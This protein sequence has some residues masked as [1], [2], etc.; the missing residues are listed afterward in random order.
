MYDE[1]SR[2]LREMSIVRASQCART[3][4]IPC[5]TYTKTKKLTLPKREK[6]FLFFKRPCLSVSCWDALVCISFPY[7]TV[8]PSLR[9]HRLPRPTAPSFLFPRGRVSLVRGLAATAPK[10]AAALVV[11][12]AGLCRGT[13]RLGL[14]SR[15][16]GFRLWGFGA[17]GLWG[18]GALGLWGFRV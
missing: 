6:S 17:L 14:G 3:L 12:L 11:L 1:K 2:A 9:P 16:S 15:V 10:P 5:W 18:F 4:P 7:T 13:A 8:L